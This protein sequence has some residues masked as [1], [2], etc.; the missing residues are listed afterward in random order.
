MRKGV[1]DGEERACV[2]LV[3]WWG[4]EGQGFCLREF[5]VGGGEGEGEGYVV[6]MSTDTVFV[7]GDKL[8][9]F[10]MIISPV[11]NLRVSLLRRNAQEI[12]DAERDV[13][14]REK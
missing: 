11:V 2:F 13:R 4:A 5:G 3:D 9:V 6:R 10:D 1:G 7:K 8:S 12:R 14:R